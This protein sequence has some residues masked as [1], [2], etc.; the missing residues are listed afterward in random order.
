MLCHMNELVLFYLSCALVS[1]HRPTR[2][3]W[4][5]GLCCQ[6]YGVGCCIIF[7]LCVRVCVRG[8]CRYSPGSSTTVTRPRSTDCGLP[9]AAREL[10]T[11]IYVCCMSAHTDLWCRIYLKVLCM[12]VCMYIRTH[13][14]TN[15]ISVNSLSIRASPQGNTNKH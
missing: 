5:L 15:H 2:Q 14:N 7:S 9:L 6:K 1:C 4:R 3:W 10:K 8:N 12:Y 13:I 11:E